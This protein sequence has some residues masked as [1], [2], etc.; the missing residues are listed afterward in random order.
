MA[1][2]PYERLDDEGTAYLIKTI[3]RKTQKKLQEGPNILIDDD[4][5]SV[6]DFATNM[7]IDALFND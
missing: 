2:P 1:Q 7:D 3:K 6:S 4:T 5:I